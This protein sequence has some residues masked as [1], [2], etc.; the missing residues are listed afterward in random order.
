[1]DLF[2]FVY[3]KWVVFGFYSD[4]WVRCQAWSRATT[5]RR[6]ARERDARERDDDGDA[7][8]DS[9]RDDDEAFGVDG[10]GAWEGTTRDDDDAEGWWGDARARDGARERWRR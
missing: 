7:R 1:M 8:D 4:A 3:E 10:G 5:L 2:Y 9:L 6:D